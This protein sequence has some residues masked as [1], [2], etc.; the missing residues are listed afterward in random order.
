MPF[1]DF[2]VDTTT[3]CA[4]SAVTFTDLSHPVDRWLWDF[5]DGTTSTAQ[6]P[7][8]NY[9][10]TGS[11]TIAL[12]ASN[13]GCPVTVTKTQYINVRPPVADFVDS[14]N[15]AN[16]FSVFFTNRSLVNP[17]YGPVSYEWRFGDP[18]NSTSTA[19]HPTFTYPALGTYN[20]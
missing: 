3:A 12:T 6:N 17:I 5:G 13:N 11:F 19:Q 8:H 18:A 20:V 4:L 14:V 15:C 9:N 1:V 2:T 16:K 10:D 7:I